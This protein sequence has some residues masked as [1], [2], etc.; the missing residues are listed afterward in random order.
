MAC[1]FNPGMMV[2]YDS[3]L[4][5]RC[6]GL[7]TGMTADYV[8]IQEHPVTLSTVTIPKSWIAEVMTER[9]GDRVGQ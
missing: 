4:F 3:P 2:E 1:D 6:S 5:G 8:T 9:E 7:V